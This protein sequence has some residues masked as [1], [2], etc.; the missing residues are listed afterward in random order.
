MNHS[1]LQLEE[2]GVT[3]AGQASP[4]LR[5]VN[6]AI[7]RGEVFGIT[8]PNGVGKTT[9][10]N[11]ICRLL[12]PSS[13]RVYLNGK[14]IGVAGKGSPV[15]ELSGLM[16]RP[17]IPGEIARSFQSSPS[18]QGLT[19][20][21]YIGD[22]GALAF[23]ALGQQRGLI[24]AFFLEPFLSRFSWYYRREAGEMRKR[25]CQWLS[26]LGLDAE[27]AEESL[28]RLSLGVRRIVDVLRALKGAQ[29]LFI[30]DEPFTNLR[31]Q[32]ALALARQIRARA[33]EGVSGL[34]T[35]HDTGLLAQ[36]VDHLY[37]LTPSGLVEL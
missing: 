18:V 22:R 9:L 2:I 24:R 36:L 20:W 15:L 10:L 5:N 33:D 1:L 28:D 23:A 12:P 7:R 35:G 25:N 3:F 16:Q 27:I 19:A 17:I 4:I 8:G 30:L 34:V 13:G 11:V 6:L 26:G 31:P 14:L 32:T 37:R 29:K 21:R